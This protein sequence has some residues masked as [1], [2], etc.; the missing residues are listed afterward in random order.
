MNAQ[1]PELADKP[2]CQLVGTDGNVFAVIGNVRRA[3]LRAGLPD[4]AAEWVQRA[5]SSGSYDEV[6]ALLHH[7]VDAL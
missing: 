1:L 7:Y 3:L 2:E 6:L 5:T 4:Y